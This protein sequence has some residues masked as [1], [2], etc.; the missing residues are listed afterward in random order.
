M[1]VATAIQ[2]PWKQKRADYFSASEFLYPCYLFACFGNHT[3]ANSL[4]SIS[5]LGVFNSLFDNY[6]NTFFSPRSIL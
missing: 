6:A 2:Q 1:T 4:S 3:K 5:Q